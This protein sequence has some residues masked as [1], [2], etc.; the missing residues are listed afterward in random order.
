MEDLVTEVTPKGRGTDL[1]VL[2][3]K[4]NRLGEQ[5]FDNIVL[6]VHLACIQTGNTILFYQQFA[7]FFLLVGLS[8]QHSYQTA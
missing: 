4:L 3:I 7:S 6:A 8:A 1:D 5:F 2:F